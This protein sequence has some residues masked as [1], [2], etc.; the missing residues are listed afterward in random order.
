MGHW[1]K[2]NFS[3]YGICSNMVAN[4][5]KE[6]IPSTLALSYIKSR[7]QWVGGLVPDAYL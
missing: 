2:F 5:L 1:P 7:L 6:D 3:E 4:S